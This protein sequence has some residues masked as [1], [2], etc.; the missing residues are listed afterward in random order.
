ML[1][2]RRF[3]PPA[4]RWTRLWQRS[5][6]HEVWSPSVLNVRMGIHTGAASP[7]DLNA[8]AGSYTG[9][10]TLTRVQRILPVAYDGQV[11]LS[12]ASAELL[13]EQLPQRSHCVIWVSIISKGWCCLNISGKW[14]RPT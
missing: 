2:A 6:Q 4:M 1:F 11:L 7:G 3:R 10:L 5:L 13:H 12:S 14:P 8:Q 9:S